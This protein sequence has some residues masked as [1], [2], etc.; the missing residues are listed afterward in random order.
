MSLP[1][2]RYHPDPVASGSVIESDRECRCCGRARGYVYSGPAYC[3]EDVDEELCPWCIADGTAAG[4]LDATFVDSEAFG[5]EVPE[6]AVEE[7]MERTPGYAAWQSEVW[8][9]CCGDATAFLF[10]AGAEELRTAGLE[11][12]AMSYIVHEL[13]ISGGAATEL[14]RSLSRDGGP[15]AYVFRCLGCGRHHLHIDRP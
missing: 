1:D 11:G 12:D 7:I 9:A 10:P 3:E 4:Q 8:P 15:T 2:F 13:E 6:A 5:D 14:L